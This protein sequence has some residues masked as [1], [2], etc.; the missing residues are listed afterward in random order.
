MTPEERRAR[1]YRVAALMEEGELSS[2]LTDIQENA[3]ARWKTCFDEVERNN[4]WR[5]VHLID[6]VRGNF[7]SIA[8]EGRLTEIRRMK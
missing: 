3:I 2:V 6:L 7:A 5:F 4:L 1:A 8:A